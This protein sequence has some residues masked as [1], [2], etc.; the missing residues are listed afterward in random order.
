M[1][2]RIL[3]AALAAVC[4]LGCAHALAAGEA[5]R[6]LIS[7]DYLNG[8]FFSGLMEQ[9]QTQVNTGLKPAFDD[10]M[11]RLD[12]L[13]GELSDPDQG[14]SAWSFTDTARPLTL[15][16]GDTVTLATGST[17]LWSAG[18]ARAQAGLVD[19]TVGSDL[20][21]GGQVTAGHRYLSALEE[22]PVTV[23]VRS[24]AARLLVQGRWTVAESN[25]EVTAFTDLVQNDDWFYDGVY[26][27]VDRGLFNGVSAT[28]FSPSATMNRAMLAT[29]LHRLAGSPQISYDGTFSDVPD[30]QWYTSGIGWAAQAG[31]VNGLGDGLFGPT[32]DVTREQIAAMLYRYARD[33]L[34]MDVSQA[35]DLS[36]YRDAPQ[37]GSWAAEG[38]TWAVGAG[39]ITGMGDGLL[40]PGS[41]ANRAQVAIMLQRFEAW[42]A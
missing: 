12:R 33:Y 16:R 2:R 18:N 17:L 41:A 25:E 10:A 30:A 9:V 26:Y 38:M 21:G 39:I 1:K 14:E 7:A 15:K 32:N 5:D 13:G 11:E 20:P 23:T 31:V 29:V 22:G 8:T 24:D 40:M 37:A 42:A 34:G 35:G 3:S 6:S 19:A 28:E 4:V 27:V 36:A